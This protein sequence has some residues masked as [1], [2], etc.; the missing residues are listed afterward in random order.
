MKQL[1]AE[2]RNLQCVD[3]TAGHTV[4][5]A[6]AAAGYDADGDDADDV[7]G[8]GGGGGTQCRWCVAQAS[9]R[10]QEISFVAACLT[11]STWWYA[12]KMAS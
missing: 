8:D 6:A 4:L 11:S 10:I 1:L 3:T 5:L 7:G 9:C 12:A 2:E